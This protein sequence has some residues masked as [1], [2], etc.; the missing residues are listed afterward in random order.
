MEKHPLK[1]FPPAN[2]PRQNFHSEGSLLMM[3]SSPVI[4]SFMMKRGSPT[5]RFDRH[6]ISIGSTCVFSLDESRS[7]NSMIQT[8][9]N[10]C[11]NVSWM[12]CAFWHLK[13]NQQPI[14]KII[15]CMIAFDQHVD[16]ICLPRQSSAPEMLLAWPCLDVYRHTQVPMLHIC[17]PL[18]YVKL[19]QALVQ[20]CEPFDCP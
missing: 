12:F 19:L 13:F 5:S 10:V 4:C 17:A 1:A 11:I 18:V 14:R 2:P 20:V 6:R 15:Y 16:T 3:N 9:I 7:I 8:I